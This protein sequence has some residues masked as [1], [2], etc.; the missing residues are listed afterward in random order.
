MW[1]ND[2]WLEKHI[3]K[4]DE[5]DYS[6]IDSLEKYKGTHPGIMMERLKK[7]NWKFEFD[8]KKI[9]LSIK[10]KFLLWIERSTGWR[11]GEYKNFELL[12]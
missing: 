12:N 3:S 9:R 5:F 2:E 8:Q 11:P 7:M 4:A 6:T 10:D 1:H